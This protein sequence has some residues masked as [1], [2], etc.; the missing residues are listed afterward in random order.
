MTD[1]TTSLS[2]LAGLVAS[3]EAAAAKTAPK[4]VAMPELGGTVFVMPL[5]T[6][7]WLDPDHNALPPTATDAQRRAWGVARWVCDASGTR[8]VKPTDAA[9]LDLFAAL[10]WAASHRILIAA[11]VMDEG[12]P[13]NG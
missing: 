4:P 13:K 12:E 7:E 2:T 9:A 8:L 3:L 5:T 1:P 6:A 10:P 11:G